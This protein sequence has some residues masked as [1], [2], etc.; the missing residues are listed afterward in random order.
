ATEE[1]VAGDLK[2]ASFWQEKE[3]WTKALLALE[4]AMGRLQ[5]A[6]P[7]ALNAQ[8]DERRREVA[9]VGRLEKVR[10][11]I[12]WGTHSPEAIREHVETDQAYEAA[13]AEYGVDVA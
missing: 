5:G 10:R 11:F 4:R 7:G 1:A 2:D 6:D 3:D 13:F 12:R 8:V 9:F